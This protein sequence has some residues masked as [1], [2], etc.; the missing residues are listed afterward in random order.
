MLAVAASLTCMSACGDDDKDDQEQRS[1]VVARTAERSISEADV[2][3]ILNR[4]WPMSPQQGGKRVRPPRY[5]ACVTA[6]QN[7]K[8]DLRS[9]DARFRCRGIYEAHE[10][11]AL[12][13]LIQTVWSDH[14]A[15]AHDSEPP[16]AVLERLYE[17]ELDTYPAA[18]RKKILRSAKLQRNLY[19]SLRRQEQ[20]RRLAMALETTPDR[21]LETLSK[22]YEGSTT[23]VQRFRVVTV[24]ECIGA[25]PQG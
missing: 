3:G 4:E 16:D 22:K 6:L 7:E 12:S 25:A 13:R 2:R 24:P 14:A 21:L 10:Y 9:N 15:R 19:A 18:L 8:A 11:F 17:A 1:A 20:D 23:C 5:R